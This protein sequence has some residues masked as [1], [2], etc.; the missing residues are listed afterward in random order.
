MEAHGLEAGLVVCFLERVLDVP[1]PVSRAHGVGVIGRD[2][3]LIEAI[4]HLLLLRDI[5]R[6]LV[7]G[8]VA[9]GP[10]GAIGAGAPDA[11]NGRRGNLCAGMAAGK[12]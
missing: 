8:R 2:D 4:P 12:Q 10:R 9:V 3:H 5:D 7:V 11:V 1:A 6:D